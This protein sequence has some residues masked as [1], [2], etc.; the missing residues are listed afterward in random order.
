[1][2]DAIISAQA[3]TKRY[4]AAVAVDGLDLSIEAGE[5]FGLLG[6]TARV[7]RRPS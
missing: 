5:V 4:G 6:P 2:S 7:R 3:L 1:M